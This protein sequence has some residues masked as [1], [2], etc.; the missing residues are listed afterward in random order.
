M[1]HQNPWRSSV[2]GGG[3]CLLLVAG[4][5]G[6]QASSPRSQPPAG[7][8]GAATS[9]HNFPAA[10]VATTSPRADRDA[11]SQMPRDSN[12]GDPAPGGDAALPQTPPEGYAQPVIPDTGK[13]SI[14]PDGEVPA[15]GNAPS[16]GNPP[17]EGAVPQQGWQ[18][19][20]P[21]TLIQLEELAPVEVID[22]Q[23]RLQALSLYNGA[24]DGVPG[25]LTRQALQQYFIKQ[26]QL[27]LQ[28]Q[29]DATALNLFDVIPTS[30]PEPL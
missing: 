21:G 1:K 11:R 17:S 16:N 28:G 25:P 12:P 22:L 3:L 15:Q 4:V 20:S 13:R 27:A 6:A 10:A 7:S 24:L 30:H 18:M 26:A 2:L 14:P 29:V 9:G 5:A 8:G 23:E 19:G